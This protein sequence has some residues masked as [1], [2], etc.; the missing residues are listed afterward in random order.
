MSQ[1][2]SDQNNSDNSAE[3]PPVRPISLRPGDSSGGLGSGPLP[4]PLKLQ[5]LGR[6]GAPPGPAGPPRPPGPPSGGLANPSGGL[7]SPPQPPPSGYL[8]QPRP[9]GPPTPPAGGSPFS[10]G[11][12]SQSASPPAGGPPAGPPPPPKVAPPPPPP[13]PAA[14]PLPPASASP[15]RIEFQQLELK[16]AKAA[17]GGPPGVNIPPRPVNHKSAEKPP[18]DPSGVVPRDW[19]PRKVDVQEGPTGTVPVDQAPAPRFLPGP[20]SSGRARNSGVLRPP[21]GPRAPLG[22]PPEIDDSPS[23]GGMETDSKATWGENNAPGGGGNRPTPRVKSQRSPMGKGPVILV[24]AFAAV[25]LAVVIWP[26]KKAGAPVSPTASESAAPVAAE[27]PSASPL[28]LASPLESMTPSATPEASETPAETPQASETPQIVETPQPSPKPVVAETPKP[29]PKPVAS[30]TPKPSPKP[31][32]PAT[33]EPVETPKPVAVNT[34]KPAPTPR[35]VVEDPPAHSDQP[36]CSVRVTVSPSDVD[37]KVYLVNDHDR[38]ADHSSGSVRLQQV[39]K[40]TYTLK[41][42]ANGY[43]TFTKKNLEV[44]KEHKLSVRLERVPPPPEP[45]YN[46]PAPGPAYDP[47][48]YSAPA[49]APYYP[50]PAPSGGSYQIPAPGI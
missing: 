1:Q 50:P 15:S 35:P 20:E 16:G 18:E 23:R 22:P 39:K 32:A 33:P 47:G 14:S 6:P 5:P 12:M 34:P 48:G 37:A 46:A 11:L 7:A 44:S 27:T 38:Y 36:T 40:G 13:G 25:L 9:G 2:G 24:T 30:A 17:A 42:I 43:E 4:A 19:P 21:D 10:P 45:V 26:P 28:A 3:R 41:I 31:V 8:G 49:P 29:S